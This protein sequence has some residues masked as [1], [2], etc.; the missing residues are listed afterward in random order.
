[1]TCH[2]EG[3]LRQKSGWGTLLT[4]LNMYHY[5]I[6]LQENSDVTMKGNRGG[7]GV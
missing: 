5:S 1:M 3:V 6:G 7:G 4:T 2:P